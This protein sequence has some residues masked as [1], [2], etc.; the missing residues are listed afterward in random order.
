[1][2]HYKLFDDKIKK[3]EA[4]VSFKEMTRD[5][6]RKDM[7]QEACR[8]WMRMFLKKVIRSEYYIMVCQNLADLQ[9]DIENRCKFGRVV[10]EVLNLL[11]KGDQT[12]HTAKKI[13]EILSLYFPN[14][15]RRGKQKTKIRKRMI[16]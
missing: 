13:D 10:D 11:E 5:K 7:G 8:I 15:F 1:M 6:K 2:K 3:M 12:I 14:I 4:A 9:M 16:I